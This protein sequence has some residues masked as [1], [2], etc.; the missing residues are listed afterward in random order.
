VTEPEQAAAVAEWA[1][2]VAEWAAVAAEWAAVAVE[3]ARV[4]KRPAQQP[5]Q[6]LHRHQERV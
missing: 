1:A 3:W 4:R 6:T 5:T 2:A